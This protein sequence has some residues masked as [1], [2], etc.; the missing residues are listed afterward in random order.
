MD[1]SLCRIDQIKIDLFIQACL[2]I[3]LLEGF[4]DSLNW[5]HEV[6]NVSIFFSRPDA[7]QTAQRLHSLYIPKFLVNNHC[8]KQ[9]F[10][11]ACLILLS[12]DQDI[13][14]FMEHSLCLAFLHRMTVL[15]N[16]HLAFSVFRSIDLIRI[17]QCATES[18]HDLNIII[19]IRFQILLDCM[20]I[21][22]RRQSGCS[23]YHHL[24]LTTD[25]LF[26]DIPE[27]L[28][29]D[30]SLLFQIMRMQFL[31]PT[32]R[33]NCLGCRNIRIIRRVLRNLIAHLIGNIVCQHIHNEALFNRLL[34]GID[35]ERM[36]G[37]IWIWLTKDFQR[38]SLR[39]RGKCKE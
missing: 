25:F 9:R 12:N 18:D 21:P 2:F 13:P 31:I 36:E 35:V 32:D 10:I 1:D 16:I 17:L 8:M 37:T 33:F 6:Q 27:C 15:I 20:V 23:N 22:H 39:C 5:I 30:R 19:I 14:L 24:A 7:V 26:R 29:N 11:K 4:F 28:D 34:H 38:F 3:E